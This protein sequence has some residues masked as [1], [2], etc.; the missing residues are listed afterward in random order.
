MANN[1]GGA[2][3]SGK[4]TPVPGTGSM[5]ASTNTSG[6]GDSAGNTQPQQAGTEAED[7]SGESLEAQLKAELDSLV[8]R[9]MPKMVFIHVSIRD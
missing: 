2:Q 7:T 9:W 1:S 6:G 4:R 5:G 3:Q 8:K